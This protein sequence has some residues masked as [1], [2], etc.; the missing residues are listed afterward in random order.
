MQHG[1]STLC[2]TTM[3]ERIR[4]RPAH[5]C[6]TT[7]TMAAA[8]D[9]T[10]AP[11]DDDEVA[12]F[13]AGYMAAFNAGDAEA[14]ARHFHPP[15]TSVPAP[16]RAE[17]AGIGMALPVL[18]DP[19][20]LL[21]QLPGYWSHSTVDRVES[22]GTLAPAPPAD[23]AARSRRGPREGLVAWVTRWDRDG[24][25]YQRIE[26][27]YLLTRHDGRLGIKVIAELSSELLAR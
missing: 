2:E 25:P 22:L 21:A 1:L 16:G 3:S 11:P 7:A 20:G 6:A 26:A 15:V 14:F 19:A 12:A 17:E 5:R 9:G 4:P 23:P 24:R 18:T 10:D 13:F 27:L 8:H